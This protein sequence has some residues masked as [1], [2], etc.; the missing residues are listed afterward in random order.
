MICLRINNIKVL[1][2]NSFS[3]EFDFRLWLWLFLCVH[4]ANVVLNY[5]NTKI[6][7]LSLLT[8]FT[9]IF[10][11]SCLQAFI[12][13]YD[14]SAKMTIE[15]KSFRRTEYNIYIVIYKTKILNQDPMNLNFSLHG[16]YLNFMDGTQ[17]NLSSIL[18]SVFCINLWRSLSY[19]AIR[20]YVHFFFIYKTLLFFFQNE[21][22]PVFNRERE[23]DENILTNLL[24]IDLGYKK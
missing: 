9:Y 24:D 18:I 19:L 10:I 8:M 22:I 13:W 20:C 14:F 1:R 21:M 5:L 17:C 15:I 4:R 23:K 6:H 2:N 12:F 3:D 11:C 16:K 7:T